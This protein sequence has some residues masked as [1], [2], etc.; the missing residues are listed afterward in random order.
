[1][2]RKKGQGSVRPNL[3]NTAPQPWHRG[4]PGF[5]VVTPRNEARAW[6]HIG[7]SE[8]AAPRNP[9]SNSRCSERNGRS[10]FRSRS[11]TCARWR[12][13]PPPRLG[14]Q[15]A[16]RTLTRSAIAGRNGRGRGE[17]PGSQAAGETRGTQS[18]EESSG[19]RGARRG[20]AEACQRA[21][22]CPAARDA[23]AIA[24]PGAGVALA[25]ERIAAF[26]VARDK[27]DYHVH[28]RPQAGTSPDG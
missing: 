6:R 15:W 22:P 13:A 7:S 12:L 17:G 27:P 3:C 4:H 28:N 26:T 10:R 18:R 8:I 16:G 20:E 14:P 1:M 19:G 23:K 25:P 5:Y 21:A 2:G 11:K 24:R 9:G